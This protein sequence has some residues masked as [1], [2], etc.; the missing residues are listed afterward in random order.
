MSTRSAS[1]PDP[2]AKTPSSTWRL[3]GI[4][5]AF[6]LAVALAGCGDGSFIIVFNSGVIVGSPRCDGPGGQFDLREQG[7]LQVLVVITSSTR[8]VVSSG[9]GTCDDLRAGQ[10]V[11]VSGRDSGDRIVAETVTVR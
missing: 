11:E 1:S 10:P 6:A 2:T 3:G 7:G 4:G 5:L 9:G 8:I